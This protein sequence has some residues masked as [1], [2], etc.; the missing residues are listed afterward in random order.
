[1]NS[2]IIKVISALFGLLDAEM[3]KNF[4]D[5][6]LDKLEDKQIVGEVDTPKEMA[7]ASAISLIRSLL[8]IN[9]KDYGSDKD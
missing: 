6:G 9:D 1:M 7:I 8:N 3:V 4:I 2:L 5:A